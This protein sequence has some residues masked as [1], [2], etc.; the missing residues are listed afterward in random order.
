MTC[1]CN[2]FEILPTDDMVLR[3]TRVTITFAHKTIR[4]MNMCH[5][6]YI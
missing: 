2:L 3:L 4:I 5:Y 1:K 6:S